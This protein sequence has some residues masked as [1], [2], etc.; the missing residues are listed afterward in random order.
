MEKTKLNLKFTASKIDEIEQTRKLALEN[1]IGD[2]SI[3]ML[4]L[5]IQKGLIDENGVHG[6]S[7][8]VAMSTIDK[9]LETSDKDELVF[10]IVEAL[11]AGGFLSRQLNVS[12]LRKM[13]TDRIAQ[14]KETLDNV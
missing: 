14:A 7:K 10:D 9:Y 12:Q 1:C 3:G 4:S 13:Q 5:F 11:V 6:V 8:Q 2:T